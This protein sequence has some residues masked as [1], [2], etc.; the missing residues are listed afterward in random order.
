MFGDRFFQLLISIC[1][2]NCGLAATTLAQVVPDDSLGD[3]NSVI[4]EN[5]TLEDAIVDLIEGGVIRGQNL[6]HSFSEFKVGS[7]RQVYFANP[8]NISNIIS[9]VTGGNP[10]EILGTLG[11]NG[12]ADLFLL[13]PNGIVFGENAVLDLNGSFLATTAESFEFDNDY[14][15]G[16]TNP[17][18]PPLLT[19]DIPVGLQF[20]SEIAGIE[21]GG[22]GHE[23]N[24]SPQLTF[25]WQARP[26]GLEVGSGDTLALIGG[27]INI[28]GG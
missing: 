11:V 12:G 16:A 13:N 10:T 2:W 21:V 26:A 6:F 8:N 15:Y 25:N 9:R 24:L 7:N 17:D 14:G 3:N 19:I 28:D 4:I 18:L 23:L 20:G 1:L 22:S 27:E 5:T